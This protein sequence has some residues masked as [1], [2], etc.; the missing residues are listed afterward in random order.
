MP[1]SSGMLMS[2]KV[3]SGF[4]SMAFSTASWPF[5]ASP[6]TLQLRREWRTP[7]APARDRRLSECEGFS[8]S[9]ACEGKGHVHRCAGGAEINVKAPA[10]QLHALLHTRNANTNVE[11]VRFFQRG[12]GS[13]GV[14]VADFQGEM[15]VAINANLG[16]RTPRMAVDVGEAL[17]HYAE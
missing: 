6:T 16:L 12:G 4:R 5:A 7:R 17:L 10:D 3:M 8:R 11:P 9:F 2:T 15:G 14:R 1:S 13:T